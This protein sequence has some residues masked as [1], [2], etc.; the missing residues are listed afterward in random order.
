MGVEIRFEI[1]NEAIKGYFEQKYY[2]LAP[3]E[4][5]KL[6]QTGIYGRYN[7]DNEA[8]QFMLYKGEDNK[9][10]IVFK[11][12]E[13]IDGNFEDE[14]KIIFIDSDGEDYLNNSTHFMIKIERKNSISTIETLKKIDEKRDYRYIFEKCIQ[15]KEKITIKLEQNDTLKCT[16]IKDS[17]GRVIKTKVWENTEDAYGKDP[18]EKIKEDIDRYL[19][20]G[21][22][23]P[24]WLE[25]QLNENKGI[26]E[27]ILKKYLEEQSYLTIR[28]GITMT[29]SG[30]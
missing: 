14:T 18:K 21:K 26:I 27:A 5:G 23:L 11:S 22:L 2:S 1:P 9:I 13:E 16:A 28:Q 20:K 7:I 29:K 4:Y 15:P 8:I 6:S 25:N 19:E 30:N 24:I 12:K 3:E 17:V 10:G